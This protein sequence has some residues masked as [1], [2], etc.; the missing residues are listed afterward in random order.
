MKHLNRGLAIVLAGG[1]L[2]V[3]VGLGACQSQGGNAPGVAPTLRPTIGPLT[4]MPIAGW[5]PDLV[6]LDDMPGNWHLGGRTVEQKLEADSLYY[7][8]FNPQLPRESEALISEE[9]AIY[10][11]VELARTYYPDWHDSN[12]PPKYASSWIE[13]PALEFAHH[14][15]EMKIAC[16]PSAVNWQPLWLCVMIARYQ[17]LIVIIQGNVYKDKWLTFEDYRTVLESA[18]RRITL[19]LSGNSP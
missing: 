8:Y 6:L 14:A 12:I 10:P 11:T 7:W 5:N 9:F 3:I 17:N 15:D 18:D 4:L 2:L 1:W 16:L 19:V 13:Q